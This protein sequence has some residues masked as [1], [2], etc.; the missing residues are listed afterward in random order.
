[1]DLEA[2]G[3]VPET[4]FRSLVGRATLDKVLFDCWSSAANRVLW[5]VFVFVVGFFPDTASLVEGPALVELAEVWPFTVVR[6]RLSRSLK[7][8]DSPFASLVLIRGV[9]LG[10]VELG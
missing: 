10:T 4:P 2:C 1:M 7:Y 5:V 3:F 8:P 9:G 6:S